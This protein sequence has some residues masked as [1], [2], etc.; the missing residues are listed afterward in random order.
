MNIITTK[1]QDITLNKDYMLVKCKNFNFN[2]QIIDG[3]LDIIV[4]TTT[5][6][7][8]SYT[9]LEKNDIIKILNK[10]KSN[11]ILPKIIYVNTKYTFNSESSDSE[12][13]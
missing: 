4:K 7:L 6:E 3:S 8:V 2:I 12:T 11:T 1:I 9:Y 13:I 5:K 10:K